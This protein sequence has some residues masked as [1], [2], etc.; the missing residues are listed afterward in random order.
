[1]TRRLAWFW[2]P[3]KSGWWCCTRI[4]E[5]RRDLSDA[6]GRNHFCVNGKS[7]STFW[8]SPPASARTAKLA[9]NS[10]WRLL[11]HRGFRPPGSRPATSTPKRRDVSDITVAHGIPHADRHSD[12]RVHESPTVAVRAVGRQPVLQR[13][14]F[15]ASSGHRNSVPE[16]RCPALRV[17]PPRPPPPQRTPAQPIQSLTD[18]AI[19]T[20]S[21]AAATK[22]RP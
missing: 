20:Q 9:A 7:R 16:K 10:G 13:L 6:F 8:A 22:R 12:D 18:L 3:S 4:I 15:S 2:P 1:M 14:T 19:G 21:A 17:V 5:H 11:S